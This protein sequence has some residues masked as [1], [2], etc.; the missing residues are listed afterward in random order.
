MKTTLHGERGISLIWTTTWMV[1][2]SGFMM[3]AVDLGRWQLARTELRRAADAAARAGAGSLPSGSVAVL[4]SATDIATRNLVDGRALASSDLDVNVGYWNTTTKT[5]ST[6]IPVGKTANAVQVIA[7]RTAARGGAVP[8]VFSQAFGAKALDA[9]AEAIAMYS[10]GV[11]VDH[12]I[13]GRVNPFLVGMPI[14][15]VASKKN[16]HNSPD[17]LGSNVPTISNVALPIEA[18]Q[19]FSFDSI[20]GDARHDP[21]LPYFNPDGELTDI[22]HNYNPTNGDMNGT[23]YYNENGIAD[24]R[25]PINALVGVFLSDDAPNM[26]AAS[27]ENLD[28]ATDGSRDFATLQPKLKQVFFIGDGLR[29]NGATQ[30]FV[31]PAG[32]TRLYLATWDFYEWNNN[33]GERTVRVYRPGSVSLVK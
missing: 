32:A 19:E 31:A 23:S 15:S 8:T 22:G 13:D 27:R 2:L 25:I 10:P 29:N 17:V 26:S 30:R 16:P 21:N 7:Y 14:G 6:T 20:S 1:L 24:A 28:F 12:K 4:L 5:F 9:K 3:L 33:A 11:N 18:G